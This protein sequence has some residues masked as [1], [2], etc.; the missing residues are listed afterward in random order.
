MPRLR[1]FASRGRP[2]R[3]RVRAR[4]R[5]SGSCRRLCSSGSD[6]CLRPNRSPSTFVDRSRVELDRG[7]YSGG[8]SVE[9][10][11]AHALKRREIFSRFG[12]FRVHDAS[13]VLGPTR[14]RTPPRSVRGRP[15]APP[16]DA[17]E[18]VDGEGAE[19]LHD[20][21]GRL[22]EG[23]VESGA[24]RREVRL[25]AV[26]LGG[27][28]VRSGPKTCV[29]GHGRGRLGRVVV[30][31]RGRTRGEDAWGR[32]GGG[33]EGVDQVVGLVQGHD[34]G[35]VRAG[36]SLDDVARLRRGIRELTAAKGARAVAHDT[37]ERSRGVDRGRAWG[38]HDRGKGVA[39][40]HVARGKRARR[41]NDPTGAD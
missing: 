19:T 13:R 34:G 1:A 9:R 20:G 15:V 22:F 29:E 27:G 5:V 26:L 21:H 18:V 17:V 37:R 23:R 2:R 40:A 10:A 38:M 36:R 16:I 31:A 12:S 6:A 30:R 28:G 32:V 24:E 11:L 25:R 14:G 35:E 3:R 8:R 7:A 4:L 33:G 39:A 41:V